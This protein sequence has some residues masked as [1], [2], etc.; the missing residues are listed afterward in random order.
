MMVAREV[1]VMAFELLDQKDVDEILL[2]VRDLDL[3][4]FE[5]LAEIARKVGKSVPVEK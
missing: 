2:L 5:D 4:T 1:L 3:V